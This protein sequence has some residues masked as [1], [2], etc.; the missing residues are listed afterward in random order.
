[1]R[2]KAPKI[3]YN[4]EKLVPEIRRYRVEHIQNLD[5]I[6]AEFEQVEMTIARAKSKFCQASIQIVGYIYDTNVRDLNC[7]KVFRIL[8]WPKYININL[9]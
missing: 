6:L 4:N 5:E 3:T 9:A 8:H 2:K 7:L 1:M